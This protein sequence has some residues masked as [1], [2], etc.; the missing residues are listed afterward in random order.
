M[1]K[2]PLNWPR[3]GA[4]NVGPYIETPGDAAPLEGIRNTIPSKSWSG[5]AMLASRM[6]LAATFSQTLTG[7]V[8]SLHVVSRS[9][10]ISGYTVGTG[11]IVRSGSNVSSGPMAGQFVILD[12]DWS[13]RAVLGDTRGTS[14]P[15]P[16]GHDANSVC[17]HPTD[18][19]ICFGMTIARDTAA[20]N[21]NVVIFGINRIS[22]ATNA[23]TH[24]TYGL[25]TDTAF[26][27]GSYP[28]MPGSGQV[29]LFPNKMTCNGVYLF[30]AVKNYV[31]VFRADNLA[32]IKRHSIDWA[33][34]VQAAE[35]ITVAST[36]YLMVLFTGTAG[37]GGPVVSDGGASRTTYFGWFFRTGVSKYSIAYAD[38]NDSPVSGGTTVLTRMRMPMGLESGDT[39]YEDHRYFRIS[40]YSI[41]SPRGPLAWDM[42]VTVGSDNSVYAYIART[43]QGF[44]FDGTSTPDGSVAYVTA[45]RANLSAAFDTTIENYID[46]ADPFDYGFAFEVGGWETDTD[47]LRK[48]FSWHATSYLNDIPNNTY[49]L[50]PHDPHYPGEAPSIFAVAVDTERDRAF[51]AG[52]RPSPSQALPNVYCLRAS[53]GTRLWDTDLKGMIQQNA[54]AVDPTTGNIVCGGNRTSGWEG[55]AV[56]QKA[57]VWELDRETGEVRRWLDFTDAVNL[58]TYLDEVSIFAV[59]YDVAVNSRGQ[60]ALALGPFRL[61]T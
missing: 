34:E 40:E 51:F 48:A 52:R 30:V 45:C 56:G 47:S 32:F 23:I 24:Q 28:A 59:T 6:G 35:P 36:D 19:D 7:P 49:D 54:I 27:A 39:G 46:P 50:G 11:E 8:Q 57:E 31:Y 2:I 25:D 61:D 13:V 42:A 20:S 12:S 21:Q 1:P 18:P 9:S 38:A 4:T 5:R 22:L 10:G 14:V 33:D 55:G 41:Q 3:K 43:N 53:D 29:D 60:V 44:N 17:W 16:G 58:N 37:I 26:S 15:T